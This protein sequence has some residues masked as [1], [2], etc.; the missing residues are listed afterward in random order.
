MKKLLKSKTFWTGVLTVAYGVYQ[1]V[2]GTPTQDGVQSI[3]L[4]LA[5]IFGRAAVSKLEK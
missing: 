3:A 5:M 4:G 2:Q 1:I